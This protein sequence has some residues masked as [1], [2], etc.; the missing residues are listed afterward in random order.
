MTSFSQSQGRETPRSEGAN[1]R[2][3]ERAQVRVNQ[4]QGRWGIGREASVREARSKRACKL[5]SRT[6]GEKRKSEN[7]DQVQDGFR[8]GGRNDG[9]RSRSK[10]E[11]KKVLRCKVGGWEEN[12]ILIK[13]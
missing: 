5:W 3:G 9:G 12:I 1:L 2:A 7:Q 4:G 6:M 13:G 8:L 11:S 10:A